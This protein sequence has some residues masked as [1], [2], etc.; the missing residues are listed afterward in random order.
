VVVA[1]ARESPARLTLLWRNCIGSRAA[2]SLNLEYPHAPPRY[3]IH[4]REEG[5]AKPRC[6]SNV[7][8]RLDCA[9]IQSGR[10]RYQRA[11]SVYT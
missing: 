2:A 1:V 4:A 11:R 6:C 10:L 8:V 9:I 3:A 7:S 5:R